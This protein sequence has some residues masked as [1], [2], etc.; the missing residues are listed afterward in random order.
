MSDNT[1]E[2]FKDP[3]AKCLELASR[4]RGRTAP[5]PLVGSVIINP[6]GEIVGQ[7]FHRAAGQPHA[8]VEALEEAGEKARGATLFVNLEPCSHHG[9]TPPC[10][11]AIVKAGVKKVVAAMEDPNPRVKG[12]GFNLLKEAGI[13]VLTGILKDEASWLNRGF[14]KSILH[15]KP[16]VTLKLATTLDGRI[17]DRHGKS[18][19]ITGAAA[20][21][22]VH[23]LRNEIDAVIVGA[24]TV[25]YDNPRLNVRDIAEKRDPIKV[26]LDPGL[27]L[28]EGFEVLKKTPVE[29]LVYHGSEA[30]VGQA[31]RHCQLISCQLNKEDR[32]DLEEILTDLNRRG[33][34]TLLCEGG[35]KLAGALLRK[36]L[37]D[38]IY[39]FIAPKVLPDSR[40]IPA[41]RGEMALSMT[42]TIDFEV[43]ETHLVDSDT[44]IHLKKGLGDR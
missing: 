17:A 11:E 19:W 29:T 33:V 1:S 35:G 8:E 31:Y 32:I 38:E 34:N 21:R 10:A 14:I 41:T 2:S 27:S 18:Q 13:E 4:A 23:R 36:D 30:P 39:W 25:R 5:N 9:R 43:I 15:K 26:I 42:E 6:E 3:M 20:R 7:G 28:D 24:G 16:W 37:V 40:A 44:L 12:S 22:Q